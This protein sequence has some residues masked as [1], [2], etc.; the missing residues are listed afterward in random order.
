MGLFHARKFRMRRTQVFLLPPIFVK[1]V[2]FCRTVI[3]SDKTVTSFANRGTVRIESPDSTILIGVRPVHDGSQRPTKKIWLGRKA[4]VIQNSW[5][6]IQKRDRLLHD[7][8][9]RVVRV[10]NDQRDKRAL[11]IER[12]FPKAPVLAKVMTVVCQ[13]NN[14]C[15]VGM[16]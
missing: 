5:T 9:L 4:R 8:R 11:L 1:I 14:N 2:Q 7:L 15:V 13:K 3:V 10:V 6:D 16:R 12:R